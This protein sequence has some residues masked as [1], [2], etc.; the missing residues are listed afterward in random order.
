MNHNDPF[1]FY[2]DIIADFNNPIYNSDLQIREN[3]IM[4]DEILNSNPFAIFDEPF[5]DPLDYMNEV[6]LNDFNFE[7]ESMRG[8]ALFNVIKY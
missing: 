2:N 8:G 6:D 5:E 3:D 1:N 7:L 4:M